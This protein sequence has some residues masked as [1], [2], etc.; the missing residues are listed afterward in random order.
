M[1]TIIGIG[2]SLLKDSHQAARKAI[3]EAVKKIGII[4]KNSFAIVF[5]TEE[6]DPAAVINEIRSGLKMNNIIGFTSAGIFTDQ[7]I[8]ESGVLIAIIKNDGMDFFLD[9]EEG[10]S[11]DQK[12]AGANLADRLRKRVDNDSGCPILLLL[13]DGITNTVG[14]LVDS[15][16]NK[17][18]SQTKYAGGGSGDNLRFLK[19]HQFLGDRVYKDAVVSALIQL[20]K[21]FGV[22]VSHGWKPISS[23]MI[24]TD[25]EGNR[26]KEL[27][28]QNAYEIY[29]DVVRKYSKE[30]INADTFA[31]F[32]MHYPLGIPQ[33]A[34]KEHYII[35][36]PVSRGDD[37]SIVCVGDVPVNS[38]VR[39]MHGDR[40]SLLNAVKEA[41]REAVR[42]LGDCRPAGILVFYC[43]SRCLFLK[44]HFIDEIKA[45][46]MCIGKEV[47][48]FGCMSYGE[49]G[50]LPGMPL[51]F[52][53]KS[54]TVCVFPG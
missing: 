17:L 23:P 50:S 35:R 30:P 36:D 15:V 52:H 1:E 8:N 33:V 21:P 40:E 3:Q 7:T 45:I 32:S 26:I 37:G 47:P 2:S 43:V 18:G 20:K 39:I 25:S 9:A 53:N 44:N 24:V 48:L 14:E 34:E 29:T 31:E 27:D 13:P 5:I 19:T 46:H 11:R 22:G 49:I 42:Q 28:W 12:K 10:L 38:I 16:F 6:Y 51:A 54:V 4:D 41:A